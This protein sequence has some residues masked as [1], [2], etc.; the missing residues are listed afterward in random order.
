MQCRIDMSVLELHA[1]SIRL[2]E[3]SS[4]IRFPPRIVGCRA[5]HAGL[6]RARTPPRVDG[7]R[8]QARVL[9]PAF[10]PSQSLCLPDSTANRWAVLNFE[11]K[12]LQRILVLFVHT[13]HVEMDARASTTFSTRRQRWSPAHSP[14]DTTGSQPSWL[15]ISSR[16]D[17]Q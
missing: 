15:F 7:R 12:M 8:G 17:S 16:D 14:A 2:F 1:P 11:I 13:D 4:T 3:V 5:R 9:K 6:W 10:D